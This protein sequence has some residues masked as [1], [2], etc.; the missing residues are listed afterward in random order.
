MDLSD[1]LSCGGKTQTRFQLSLWRASAGVPSEVNH[2]LIR[3]KRH[4]TGTSVGLVF[5][6]TPAALFRRRPMINVEIISAERIT[7]SLF[8]S[9][10]RNRK[11]RAIIGLCVLPHKV[12][13]Y[14]LSM[15][16]HP[17]FSHFIPPLPF[18]LYQPLY[19]TLIHCLC[20]YLVL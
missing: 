4:R 15:S 18:H 9:S 12:S 2:I 16:V 10:N 6:E 13:I 3:L 14:L 1:Y 11:Q 8:F 19:S 17:S 5:T 20:T 7:Q